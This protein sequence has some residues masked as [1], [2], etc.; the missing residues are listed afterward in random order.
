MMNLHKPVNTYYDQE[1]H[2]SILQLHYNSSTSMLL[3]LP[4]K[5]LAEVEEVICQNHINKWLK[6]MKKRYGK[7]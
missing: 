4:D 1:I 7:L 6:W 5:G 2:T 3:V